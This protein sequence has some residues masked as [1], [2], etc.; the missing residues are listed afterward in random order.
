MDF[1]VGCTNV[2]RHGKCHNNVY[3][4]TS[5]L[6]SRNYTNKPR[7][8]AIAVKT[9]MAQLDQTWLAGKSEPFR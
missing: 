9:F 8:N 4:L 1:P 5:L 2:S 6:V 7:Y 3:E